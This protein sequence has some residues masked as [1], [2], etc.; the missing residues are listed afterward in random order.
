MSTIRYTRCTPRPG[1]NRDGLPY[2]LSSFSCL[3]VTSELVVPLVA[4]RVS[5]EPSRPSP[6][7]T[8]SSGVTV[9]GVCLSLGSGPCVHLSRGLVG[10][11]WRTL[12]FCPGL[13][14]QWGSFRF[15]WVRVGDLRLKRFRGLVSSL[16]LLRSTV[17]VKSP[18]KGVSISGKRPP[19]KFQ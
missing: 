16:V 5:P 14:V 6:V 11:P 19:P 7:P 1:L 8:L 3:L 18:L 15:Y 12:R 4:G 9:G 13:K 10:E 2:S 17:G